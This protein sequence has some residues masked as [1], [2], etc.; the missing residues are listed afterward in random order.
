M[1]FTAK[2]PRKT[3]KSKFGF[4]TCFNNASSALVDWFILSVLKSI[5]KLFR[6]NREQKNGISKRT[7]QIAGWKIIRQLE[8]SKSAEGEFHFSPS[9]C[10]L[11]QCSF[12]W[13][14]YRVKT[15]PT[16]PRMLQWDCKTK[17]HAAIFDGWN[18]PSQI[19]K[20]GRNSVFRQHQNN[21]NTE[22]NPHPPPIHPGLWLRT[23][24]KS[25][26]IRGSGL[27]SVST[28]RNF[29][30]EAFFLVLGRF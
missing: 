18:E 24:S 23:F 12:D 15:I 22:S 30:R 26:P 14:L 28:C 2:Q 4:A 27:W 1:K 21:K 9:S 8:L 13:F 25:R 6:P 5:P 20:R 3:L 7:D 19:T 17:K 16:T 10:S 29:S 11:P